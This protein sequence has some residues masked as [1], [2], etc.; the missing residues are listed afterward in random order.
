MSRDEQ[1]FGFNVCAVWGSVKRSGSR[2]FTRINADLRYL[3]KSAAHIQPTASGFLPSKVLDC[4]I[5]R[6]KP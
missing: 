6:T 3:R 4:I 1:E 2:R 5:V